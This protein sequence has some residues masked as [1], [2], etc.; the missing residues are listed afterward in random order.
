MKRTKK[1]L[2]II[3]MLGVLFFPQA[4]QNYHDLST[5]HHVSHCDTDCPQS[6]HY[7]TATDN[8]PIHEF[9]F[10]IPVYD[11]VIDYLPIPY[12]TT[13]SKLVYQLVPSKQ[14][15]F[16]SYFLRGPPIYIF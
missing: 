1:I 16:L 15:P 9:V 13:I 2:L 14:K 8:C 5:H 10:N 7:H 3:L 4:I 6:D 11:G 12:E